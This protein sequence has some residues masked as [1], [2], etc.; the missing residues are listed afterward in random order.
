[1]SLAL[2][3]LRCRA[4]T[5]DLEVDA[6]FS[7]QV[8]GLFGPS[9][10]GKTSILEIVAGL[11][12]PQ[13]GRVALGDTVFDDRARGVFVPPEARR[14]GYVP[15]DGALFPHLSV[16]ANIRYGVRI[17][18]THA[19]A[20]SVGRVCELLDLGGRLH[21]RVTDL[22]GGECQR[23]AIARALVTTPRLML[24]DEPLASLD[25][26][27]KES[28]LPYLRRLRDEL[29]IP[30]LYVSHAL[31]EVV[32][33]CDDLAVI[34]R[35]RIV[36]HGATDEVL[37]RP[38]NADVARLVGVETVVRA[39]VESWADDLAVLTLGAARLTALAPDLPAGTREVLVTIRAEDVILLQEAGP[40]HTSARNRL[41]ATVRALTPAGATVRVDLDC[42]FP[43]V[44]LLTRQAVEELALAPGRSVHALI[45][46]PNVHVI[47]VD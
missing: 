7:G 41:V 11:R 20:T 26:A 23:V 39:R 32:A 6:I 46:A 4:G 25:T 35:G 44:A 28:I 12:R 27:R 10:A 21:R 34:D 37:R 2:Q 31:P 22:S 19:S 30:M 9:G 45:K 18:T 24:L 43:L 38:A 47:P 8:T 13:A 3:G 29:R 17:E 14:I 16:E 1:M 15:Q 33:L 5:F 36:Q 40:L 42:G